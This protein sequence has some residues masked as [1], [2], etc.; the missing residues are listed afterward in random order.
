MPAPAGPALSGIGGWLLALLVLQ[1]FYLVID[2]LGMAYSAWIIVAGKRAAYGEPTRWMLVG[3]IVLHG[4]N[5][6]AAVYAT[7]LLATRRARFR[8]VFG[9]QLV[10]FALV[11]IGELAVYC[12][13][14]GVYQD[15]AAISEVP[16]AK[17]FVYLAIAVA[18]GLYVRHSERVRNTFVR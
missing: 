11:P 9:L 6:A 4:T 17:V 12:T 14:M 1:V 13:I 15:R 5:F 2:G 7:V 16:I 10:L 3:Q 8:M 18:L